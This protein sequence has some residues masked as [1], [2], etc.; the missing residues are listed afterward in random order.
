MKCAEQLALIAVYFA[1][2]FGVYFLTDPVKKPKKKRKV[3]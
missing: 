2:T 1:V 3:Q